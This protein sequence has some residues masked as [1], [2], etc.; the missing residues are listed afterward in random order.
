MGIEEFL[1]FRYNI[2]DV[3]FSGMADIIPK[4]DIERSEDKIGS[5]S[6]QAQNPV[7]EK[8]PRVLPSGA[9]EKRMN[10]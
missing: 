3:A 10:S 1:G 5:R 2:A 7:S 9:L 6:K 4:S 8:V